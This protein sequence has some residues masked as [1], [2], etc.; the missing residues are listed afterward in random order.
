MRR[1]TGYC[2]A[3]GPQRHHTVIFGVTLRLCRVLVKVAKQ[4][5][6]VKLVAVLHFIVSADEFITVDFCD[7]RVMVVINSAKWVVLLKY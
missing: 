5:C 7:F 2:G 4:V 3:Q 6:I 1:Q